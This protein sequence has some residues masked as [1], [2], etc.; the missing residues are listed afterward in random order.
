ME[1]GIVIGRNINWTLPTYLTN[2]IG[3]PIARDRLAA[4]EGLAHLYSVGNPL[5]KSR[6]LEQMTLLGNDDSRSVSTAAQQWL[7]QQNADEPVEERSVAGRPS[8]TD[9]GRVAA[10]VVDE[11]VQ[12]T[13]YRPNAVQ[14]EIWYPL[15]AFARLAERRADAPRTQPDP[16][17]EVRALAARALGEEAAYGAPRVDARAGCRGRAN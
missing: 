1:G 6:A 13:V 3:S 16:I 5:V 9:R 15:L 7:R 11:N 12:F 17:E 10:A 4:I 2:A 8:D 14:P